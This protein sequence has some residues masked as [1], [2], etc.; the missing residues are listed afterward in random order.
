MKH[1]VAVANGHRVVL[2]RLEIHGD[3]E[4]GADL[5]L[6][7]VEFSD[8]GRIVID[9]ADRRLKVAFDP[10][11]HFDDARLVLLERKDRDLDRGESRVEFQH[12]ASIFVAQFRRRLPDFLEQLDAVGAGQIAGVFDGEQRLRQFGL[13]TGERL[14]DRAQLGGGGGV[15]LQ[16][17]FRGGLL[18]F[19]DLLVDGTRR[20]SAT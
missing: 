14:V 2:E 20:W 8:A 4:R 18:G 17:A 10:L 1:R 3:A 19:G 13:A 15:R 12:D 6:A 16:F 7:A 11:R 9:D 5:V